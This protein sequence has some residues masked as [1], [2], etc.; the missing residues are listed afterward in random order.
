M[1]FFI[2]VC[3]FI[4]TSFFVFTQNITIQVSWKSSPKKTL[5]NKEVLLPTTSTN[6]YDAGIPVFSSA[7][8]FY[9]GNYQVTVSSVQTQQANADEI[10]YF[11][12]LCAQLPTQPQISAAVSNARNES[13]LVSKCYPFFMQN[14]ILVKVSAYTLNV[15]SVASTFS[16]TKSYVSN[17]VLNTG[18]WYKIAVENDGVYKLDR[19]FFQSMGLDSINPYYL[20]LYGNADGILSENNSDYFSDDLKKNAIQF[21]GD[22]DSILENNEYFLFFGRGPN[23]WK[24]TTGVV[25]ERSM[26]IYSSKNHYFIRLDPSETPLRIQTLSDSPLSSTTDV[27]SYN[28]YDIHELENVNLVRGGQRWYGEVFDAI[29]TQDFTFNIPN[30]D[31]STPIKVDYAVASNGQSTTN[32][33]FNVLYNG[34]S[35]NTLT[36]SNV[37]EDYVRNGTSFTINPTGPQVKFSYTLY[38]ANAAVKAYLDYIRINGRRNLV[39]SGDF[40]LFR[41]LNSVGAGNVSTFH[42]SGMNSNYMVWDVSDKTIPRA[43]SGS[44]LANTFTFKQ[45]T[46][47]LREFAIFNTNYLEPEF[48]SAIENQNLHALTVVDN[49]IVAPKE[50]I[51]EA[52]RLANLHQNYGTSSMVVTLE[53]I[54][55]EFS[56][57]NQDATAIRRFMKMFYDRASGNSALQPKYLCLFGDATYDPKN[58]TAN[59]NYKV[60]TYEFISSEYHISALV[61]DDYFGMLDD[62]ESISGTDLMDIGVGRLLISNASHAKT[63]VDKIEHYLKNGIN[64]AIVSDDPNSCCIDGQANTFGDWR[65]IYTLI[66]DD[67]NGGSFITSDAEPAFNQMQTIANE[68]NCEKIYTDAYTQT[69]T[70]GGHRY[71]DVVNII[72][73]RISRGSLVTNY[74]GHGSPYGAAEER[75]ITI[76]QVNDWNNT[77]RMGLFVSATCDFTKFDDPSM[78]SIGEL[79]SLNP[80]GGAIAMM[81]TTRSVY[82]FINTLVVQSLYSHIVQRD[83]NNEPLTFGEL[84][85]R[86]KNSSGTTDNRRCFNLIGDPALK[87]N[88]PKWKIVT[89]SINHV[90]VTGSLDTIKALTK[91]HVVGHIEDYSGNKLTSFNGVLSPT[92]YDKPKV[93]HTLGNDSDSPIIAFKTQ[94]NALYKGRASIKNGDFKFE[95]IVP[96]DI[97]FSYGRGKISYYADNLVEDADGWDTSFV[98]GGINP[99]PVADNVGPDLKIYMNDDSF[100]NGSITSANPLLVVEAFDE[101]GINTVGNGIG[102]DITAVLD[103][104]T[105]SPINLNEYYKSDLDSYQSGKVQYSLRNLAP[106]P[107]YI[108]VKLWDVNNNSNSIRIDF[109]VIENEDIQLAHVL[110]YPNP[111][112]TRTLFMFEHNQSCSFLDTQIQI[113]TVSGRLVKT[114]NKQVATNGFRV[115]GI[116]WDGKDDYGD[117]LAK[118]VY[119]YRLSVTLPDGKKAQKLEKLVLLK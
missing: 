32:N 11:K 10:H 86:T 1:K 24:N 23:V 20:N 83:A 39:A 98:V 70:A 4:F 115:E 37:G 28:Y 47:T 62:S 30:V 13:V 2:L 84:L 110:N 99:N 64:S 3:V 91:M 81:T 68:M 112:T 118:G 77:N 76:P 69:S 15:S 8:K 97:D 85:R 101:F 21:V 14:G 16:H 65:Q 61:T 105:G 51:T 46:D 55:N 119:V 49:F 75:I 12:V 48:V 104:N 94:K 71:P 36:L 106:G 79:M 27:Y 6:E 34:A 58:R 33:Y 5:Y 67:E 113:Y 111:F 92:I 72:N 63:Q 114:I 52:T 50:F 29:L 45:A 100:V 31:V 117:Q 9:K 54:Y 43:I 87:I 59:N 109:T 57:G 25:F 38:R 89:D 26:H 22:G 66:T 53:Q 102:H 116:E 41:D 18:S 88:L 7:Q 90:E 74:I 93:V 35:V 96:K 108:E 107:H 80:K 73:D 82:I 19:S 40:L 78:E 44:L 56:S 95:F 17:S 42:V 60:P 103:G